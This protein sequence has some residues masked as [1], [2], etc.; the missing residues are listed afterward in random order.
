MS[1]KEQ[2]EGDI[3]KAMLSKNKKELIALRSIKSA[4]LI[5][6]TEKGATGPVTKDTEVKILMK[7]AKQ[8][9]DSAEIYKS[10]ERNDLL[11]T[12]LA[13]LEVIS[14][15]LPEQM[16]DEDLVEKLK[17]IIGKVGATGPQDMGKVMGIATKELSGSADGKTIS[18]H[19][20]NLLINN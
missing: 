1:L 12:E 10:Q 9:R 7:A 19:V 14:K 3:K 5:A 11:E 20:R 2:I 13:E 4:I 18:G 8:R 16:S 17:E 6:E 15:Y